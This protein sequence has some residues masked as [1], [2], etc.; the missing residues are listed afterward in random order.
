MLTVKQVSLEDVMTAIGNGE[1]F[2]NKNVRYY[3]LATKTQKMYPVE[4]ISVGHL[5]GWATG[6]DAA[7]VRTEV[8]K[9]WTQFVNKETEG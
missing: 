7:F 4:T 1:M 6:D 5:R 3:I 8:F 9:D 2:E